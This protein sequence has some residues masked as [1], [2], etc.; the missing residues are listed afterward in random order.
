MSPSPSVPVTDVVEV[1]PSNRPTISW[2]SV[3]A[4]V[5]T[6]IAVQIALAELFIAAG[7]AMYAPFD[8]TAADASTLAIGTIIAW[9]ICALAGLFLGGWVAGRLA[10]YHSPMIAG[11]HGVLVWATGAVI[12][13]VLVTTVIGMFIGGTAKLVGDGMQ[14]AATGA[15][16]VAPA[17]AE[18]VAPS[19]DAISN[20]VEEAANKASN[21]AQ[22]GTL[23][24]RLADASRMSDLMVRFFSRDENQR[25]SQ[26]EEGEL[27]TV[28]ASQVGISREAAVKTLAQWRSSWDATLAR[29][30]TAVAEAKDTAAEAAVAAKNYT[31]TASALAFALMLVGF[32]AAMFGGVAGSNVYRKYGAN[33]GLSPMPVRKTA[34]SFG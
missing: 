18:I 8:P 6:A 1:T 22:A 21:A 12:T 24:T 7:L 9:V 34:T 33:E 19:W 5:L 14:A 10:H 15:Q 4:G 2:G 28:L 17:V 26:A 3:I 30:D 29:Y 13:A 23:D 20:Q 32:V 27:A 11:L 31:A 25:L 16:A